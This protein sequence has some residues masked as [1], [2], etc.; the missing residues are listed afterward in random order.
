M[1]PIEDVFMLH[2]N[3]KL[4]LETMKRIGETGHSRV[5]V[6]EEVD[7]PVISASE[8]PNNDFVSR[9]EKVKKIVGILFVKQVNHADSWRRSFGIL[10]F[11]CF[12]S[13]CYL[14]PKVIHH[15]FRDAIRCS[16]LSLDA[17]PIKSLRLGTPLCLP[18]NEPVLT[19]LDKFQ[20]GR[21]HIAIVSRM[22]IEKAAS[23]KAEV[24]KSL[25]RK[26]KDRIGIDDSDSS[27]SES[28]SEDDKEKEKDKDATLR[29]DS[30]PRRSWR[31]KKSKKNEGEEESADTVDLEKGEGSGGAAAT[32][33]VKATGQEKSDSK[34][35]LAVTWARVTS[36]GR[37]QSMPDDAVLN[38]DS[39]K[40]VRNR[41]LLEVGEIQL[42]PSL[43]SSCKAS[44]PV[45]CL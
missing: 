13:A 32:T 19:T 40:E 21:S 18:Q 16:L 15:V 31:K 20:E 17:T 28:E 25:T 12:N 9:T 22:T 27:S 37:E 14:T 38:K 6:Y 43:Y 23:V 10:I 36:T 3:A 41:S 45:L 4:D 2:I 33:D 29:G 26:L 8:T 34:G 24:K 1:T 35:A 39:A 44:T 42:T 5:P 7:V 11:M 30:K